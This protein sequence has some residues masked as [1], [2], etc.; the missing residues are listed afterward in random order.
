LIANNNGLEIK[1]SISQDDALQLQVGD[2]VTI[3]STATGTISQIAGAIDPSTG[4]VAI[5]IS[6]NENGTLQ[7]GATVA[8]AFSTNKDT[9]AKELSIPLAAI[10]MTGSGPVVFSVDETNT[11]VATSVTLGAI[12]GE[13]VVITSGITTDSVIVTDGRGLKAGTKVTV[14]NK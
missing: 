1:T 14:T 12:S 2:T 5:K 6:I 11:L 9:V 13:N 10:K 7:N 8:I 4:K 3:D